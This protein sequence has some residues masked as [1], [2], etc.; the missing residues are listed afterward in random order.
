LRYGAKVNPTAGGLSHS[1]L[2]FAAQDN[3]EALGI[4][5]QHGA[6]VKKKDTEGHTALHLASMEGMADTVGVLIA[7]WPDG[8]KMKD[9]SG[10]TALHLA[11]KKRRPSW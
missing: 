10:S 7:F 2:H 3:A 11:V 6:D 9:L 1:P 8:V 5:L 4:L